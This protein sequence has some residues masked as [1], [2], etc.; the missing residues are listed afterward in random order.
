MMDSPGRIVKHPRAAY[1]DDEPVIPQTP[2]RQTEDSSID[3]THYRVFPTLM[4]SPT[5]QDPTNAS[6][7][8]R[9]VKAPIQCYRR[10]A[11]VRVSNN[12]FLTSIGKAYARELAQGQNS[13]YSTPALPLGAPVFPALF[14]AHLPTGFAEDFAQRGGDTGAQCYKDIRN[15]FSAAEATMQPM[16]EPHTA[17]GQSWAPAQPHSP[18]PVIPRA[19]HPHEED[20]LP[21]HSAQSPDPP[22]MTLSQPLDAGSHS[23]SHGR[24]TSMSVCAQSHGSPEEH[25]SVSDNG[26]QYTM[27]SRKPPPAIIGFT[28]PHRRAR[29]GVERNN[30]QASIREMMRELLGFAS[31]KDAVLPRPPAAIQ[32]IASFLN[33]GPGPQ[34]DRLQLDFVTTRDGVKSHWNIQAGTEFARLFLWRVDSAYFA[35]DAFNHEDLNIENIRTLF[36]SKIRYFMRIYKELYFPPP[37][38]IRKMQKEFDRRTSRRISLFR[39][40]DRICRDDVHDMRE[41][42]AS[43][44][45]EM[46]SEDETDHERSIPGMK[47]FRRVEKGWVNPQLTRLFHGLLDVHLY[48]L[49]IFGEFGAGN[50]FRQR[51][52]HPPK[53][54]EWTGVVT[55]LPENFYNPRWLATLTRAEYE[56]LQ[57]K[58]FIHLEYSVAQ[59]RRRVVRPRASVG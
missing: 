8:P 40:R 26:P 18:R 42:F 21:T 29:K 25:A 14:E 32:D 19:I 53:R 57:A 35:E 2:R 33:G 10:Y 52:N 47:V 59:L 55:G 1:D 48:R 5:E 16:Q 27:R 58:P 24:F 15:P 41:I 7:S 31:K 36:L 38:N 50:Q 9:S 39:L 46:I 37:T 11:S 6:L 56:A 30:L 28:N 17:A 13:G 44:D 22:F 49:N 45:D 3:L 34:I 20:S 54:I 12:S 23:V 51:I 43:V 4:M